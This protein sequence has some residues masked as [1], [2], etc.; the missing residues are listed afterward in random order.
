MIGA[1]GGDPGQYARIHQLGGQA[2]RGLSVTLPARP[3]LPFSPDLKLQPKAKKD[4]LKI[5]T[6]H[7]RQ[8]TT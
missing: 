8:A 4:L 5:G 1:G 3:Y 7:L 2:G 6:E